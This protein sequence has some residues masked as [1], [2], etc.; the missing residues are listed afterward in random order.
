MIFN[1][2]VIGQA[3]YTIL[4]RRHMHFLLGELDSQAFGEHVYNMIFTS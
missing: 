3:E 4:S 1:K 2:N